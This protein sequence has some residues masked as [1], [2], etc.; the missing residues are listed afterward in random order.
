MNVERIRDLLVE[1]VE[2]DLMVSKTS[3]TLT[4]PNDDKSLLVE[5][6][7][8]VSVKS[9]TLDNETQNF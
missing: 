6:D 8:I 3:V 5:F 9:I 1:A 4:L 2:S 7:L